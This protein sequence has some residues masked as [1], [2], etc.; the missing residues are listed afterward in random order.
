RVGH[1]RVKPRTVLANAALDGVEEILVAVITD[2]GILVGCD[3][4][5]IE[6]AE[7]QRESET[8]GILRTARRGVTD[9]AV[10]SLGEAFAPLDDVGLG[11]AGRNSGRIGLS[12]IGERNC[13]AA[14]KR[15]GAAR[16]GAPC[17]GPDGNDESGNNKNGDTAHGG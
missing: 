5:R 13:R 6:R 1:G 15:E 16:E 12:I 17:E 14:G 10:S 2:A 8:P 11:E 9:H 3:V 4:G 7:W